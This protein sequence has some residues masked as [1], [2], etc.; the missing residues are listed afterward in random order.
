[1][2]C[3]YGCS[4]CDG[5]TSCLGCQGCQGG[6]K[7]QCKGCK[8]TCNTQC[9]TTCKDFCN[10]GLKDILEVNTMSADGSTTSYKKM[11]VLEVDINTNPISG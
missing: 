8:T 10:G 3:L 7:G 6:C 5:C 11:D 9:K 1:M 2:G 4:G